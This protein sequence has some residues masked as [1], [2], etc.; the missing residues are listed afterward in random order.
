MNM[1]RTIKATHE[2]E[3]PQRVAP[4]ASVDGLEV[5]AAGSLD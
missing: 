5:L 1:S 4:G 2:D 3:L